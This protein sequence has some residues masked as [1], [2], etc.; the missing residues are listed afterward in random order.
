MDRRKECTEATRDHAEVGGSSCARRFSLPCPQDGARRQVVERSS[1]VVD[2]P[3]AAA[4]SEGARTGCTRCF[5]YL[6]VLRSTGPRRASLSFGVLP[7]SPRRASKAPY[8]SLRWGPLRICAS[9]IESVNRLR[10]S[11]MPD[12]SSSMKDV[13]PRRLSPTIGHARPIGRSEFRR[14]SRTSPSGASHGC[15]PL[16]SLGLA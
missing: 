1:S 9:P 4:R 10:A 6:A 13:L 8:V 14:L 12:T 11:E 5:S 15:Q 7:P 3:L 16:E 2:G